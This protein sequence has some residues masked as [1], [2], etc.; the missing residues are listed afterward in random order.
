M[1][2]GTLIFFYDTMYIGNLIPDSSAFSKSTLY[3][4]KFFV[5]TLL[6]PGL[7]NFENYFTRV[8]DE[9][10]C[11]VFCKFFG[12]DF[13][14]DW[15]ENWSFP[16]LWL[17]LSFPNCW[18]VECSTLTTSTF[19]IWNSSAGCPSPSLALFLVMLPKAHLTLDSRMFGSSWVVIP[20]WL[21]GSLNSF[22]V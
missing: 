9:C 15:N 1:L 5:H 19:R 13:L 3:I 18:H 20:S 17:L 11:A 4:L 2:F 16:I 7:K 12:I 6:K 8:W 21:S 14:W 10:N 22:F